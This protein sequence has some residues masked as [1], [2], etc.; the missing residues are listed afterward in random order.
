MALCLL[1][2]LVISTLPVLLD[3]T[4]YGLDGLR[5]RVEALWCDRN[6]GCGGSGGSGGGG[7]EVN[8]RW[9]MTRS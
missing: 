2:S 1:H 9:R 8:G 5:A 7:G 4:R 3:R 6:S